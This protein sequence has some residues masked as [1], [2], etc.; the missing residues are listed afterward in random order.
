[1]IVGKKPQGNRMLTIL[2]VAAAGLALG[3]AA[4]LAIA[5][6]NGVLG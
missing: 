1:M 4:L 3:V 6:S 2:L 5:I